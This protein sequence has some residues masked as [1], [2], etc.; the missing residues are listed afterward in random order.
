MLR[1]LDELKIAPTE[2]ADGSSTGMS[3]DG[4]KRLLDLQHDDGGWG[5]WKTDENHPFMTAYALWALV[6]TLRRI[7]R[8]IAGAS[9]QAAD[10]D[11]AALREVSARRARS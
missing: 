10:G 1:A 9:R 8:S 2:R 11:G 6:E 7:S 4:I 3:A 5:W